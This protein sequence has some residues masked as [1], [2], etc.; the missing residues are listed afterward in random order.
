MEELKISSKTEVGKLAG[1]IAGVLGKNDQVALEAIGAGAINQAMKAIITARGFVV[2]LGYD[3]V[4]RPSFFTTE[5][6]GNEKSAIRITV[7][8]EMK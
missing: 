6:E 5:I 3:L 4:C 7:E 2:P 8:K 1:A